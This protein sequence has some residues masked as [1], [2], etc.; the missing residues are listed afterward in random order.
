MTQTTRR[1]I[2]T[3]LLAAL[4]AIATA[5][6]ASSTFVVDEAQGQLPTGPTKP[7]TG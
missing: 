6:V 4:M 2:A 1:R 5:F 3:L 7:P